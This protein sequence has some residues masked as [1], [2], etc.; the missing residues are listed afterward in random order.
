MSIT[1]EKGEKERA[2]EFDLHV[3]EQFQKDE[4][5]RSFWTSLEEECE[6]QGECEEMHE[7]E[8]TRRW[9]L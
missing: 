1:R 7:Q 9:L 2:L 8:Y 5:I 3:Q 6:E 4:E